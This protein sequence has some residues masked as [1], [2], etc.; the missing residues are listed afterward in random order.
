MLASPEIQIAS[1]TTAYTRSPP[2]QIDISTSA[3]SISLASSHW[4]TAPS[5]NAPTTYVTWTVYPRNYAAHQVYLP[6]QWL[7]TQQVSVGNR[8]TGRNLP[9]RLKE[10]RAHGR[11]GDFEKSAIVKHSYIKDH[12]IDWQAAQLITPINTWHPR[13]IREA[14]EI[15][16][17]DT[18]PQ[19]IGFDIS[20]IWRPLLQTF[21]IQCQQLV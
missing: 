20:D 21:Y 4:S 16:K 12:Q 1:C 17:H 8:E 6:A 11:R 5:Y 9:M 3:P 15:F 13:C 14:I 18:V 7:Q 10:H 19:D 2:I